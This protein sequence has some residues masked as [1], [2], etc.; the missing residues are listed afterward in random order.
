MMDR[1]QLKRQAGEYA[2]D[3]FVKSGMVVG[4]GHGSTAKW[5]VRKIAERIKAGALT[6]IVA[7]PVSSETEQ[8]ARNLGIPLTDFAHHP[9]VDMTI[10]GAD[11]VDPDL[12]LIKGGGGALLQEKIVAQASKREVIVVDESKLS[13]A[14]GTKYA[15]P[16]EVVPFGWQSILSH[17]ETLGANW[18]LRTNGDSTPYETDQR[19]YILDCTFPH[20]ADPRQLA[21]ALSKFAAV[22]EHGLFIDISTDIIVARENGIEHLTAKR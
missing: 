10:D 3:N 17:L 8:E 22:V 2:V 11:E 13:P 15:L 5:A 6:N 19:N 9:V 14:L 1:T 18:T 7:I 20:I 4:L 12:Q 16:V 21:Y